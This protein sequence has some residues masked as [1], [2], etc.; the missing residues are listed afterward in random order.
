MPEGIKIGFWLHLYE[1]VTVI[2]D[3]FIVDPA[4]E[5][6]RILFLIKHSPIA[7]VVYLHNEPLTDFGKRHQINDF[8]SYL[9][10]DIHATAKVT[11]NPSH[12]KHEFWPWLSD[13]LYPVI[14]RNAYDNAI[15]ADIKR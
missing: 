3:I 1:S 10:N 2:P 5:P 12:K 14:G 7:W 15:L 11:V 6:T 9:S 13:N 8:S 4:K